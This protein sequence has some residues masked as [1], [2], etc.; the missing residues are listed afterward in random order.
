M[1]KEKVTVEDCVKILKSKAPRVKII[2]LLY[3]LFEWE[4]NFETFSR[5]CLPHA[6]TKPF[7]PFHTDIISDFMRDG[8]GV[9]AAPRGHGKL[10]ANST[11]VLT[12]NG[13]TTHGKLKQ[14]DY[15]FN[16]SGK[17]IQVLSESTENQSD[18]III[19]R[20]GET[21]RC[22]G[23][24][25]W[26]VW[27]RNKKKEVTIETK[28]M[29][30]DWSE[31]GVRSRYLLPLREALEFEY[32]CLP[33]DPYFL[34]LWLGDG[35]S[36]KCCITHSP[37]DIESINAIP[38]KHSTIQV[39]KDTGVITTCFAYQNILQILRRE[40]L[41]KNKHIPQI[42]QFASKKQRLELLAGLV[43]S[44]GSVDKNRGRV[45][46]VNINKR[47][48]D[49]VCELI[50]SLGMRPIV[51]QQS[52]HSHEGIIGRHVVYTIQF[53]PIEDIPTKIPRKKILRL[54][55]RPRLGII[56]VE[57]KPNGE[58]GK[59][60]QVDSDDGLYL[61]GKNLIPT[62]N[63]TLIGLAFIIWLV[64]YNK[65]RYIV[66]TSQ[67]HEK[68]VQFLEPVKKELQT[69]KMLKF[70]YNIEKARNVR[71]DEGRNREDCF[72]YKNMRIHALS[73]EKNIRGLK[74]GVHRPSLIVLDD[75]DDDQRVLNPELR[76]K[77]SDK[78]TKQIIPALDPEIGRV[79]MVGTIIHHDSLLSKRLRVMD[80]KVYKAIQD[81]GSI[82][83]PDLFSRKILDSIK[84]RIGSSSFQS[85]YLNNP[86]DNSSAI[87][88]REWVKAS[89]NKSL[90]FED[91]SKHTNQYQGVDFA[92]SDRVS[93][94]KSAFVA[95]A[96]EENNYIITQC[97]TKKGLSITQQ[98]DYIE[99]L[100]KENNFKMNGLEENSIRG[101][102]KELLTYNF[103]Y[104]L[105]WT[106]AADP[107]TKLKHD[108]DFK[109]KRYTVGKLSMID[110]LA[111]RFENGLIQI[112]YM[113]EHDKE[114]AHQIT[115]ELCTYARSDG[116]LVETGVHGDI[117]I[118]LGYAFECA[119]QQT[120]V[121]L[122]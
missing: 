96:K 70:I 94:D 75:I 113:T 111:T 116:K 89:Y 38:Y 40:K 55:N 43:D 90:S 12:L 46:F 51:T 81:D 108:I 87:I 9:L 63:S 103:P 71:D 30:G 28:T 17:P 20:D 66:Y 25:E 31:E 23:N 11:P 60:I 24:H 3:N 118:A 83:F 56:K 76:K 44:D 65:E 92:F 52:P 48:I 109:E 26:R 53:N 62:H 122:F 21:I 93:A 105:F 49:N 91:K 98:F 97:I 100:S 57:Y 69:N 5:F 19:T 67:N 54:P 29:L 110:R 6:F 16:P 99:Q 88:K 13:W 119:E 15:V 121:I 37:S 104:K 72:D 36:S 45:R 39:H 27:D 18:F 1:I 82:L 120:G 114:L 59:C 115:D 41:Y 106:S 10:C 95:I 77:D 86:V 84:R 2:K 61:V 117:P 32:K 79:K 33:L 101:M 102:S 78:L 107:A 74:Y 73:F 50:R 68:S 58:K 7:A 35:S 4:E 34:G 64:V 85:E 22:H 112:P 42:Y 8:D 47:L 80:G 14:G